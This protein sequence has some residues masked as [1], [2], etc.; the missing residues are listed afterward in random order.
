M[1]DTERDTT[2]LL[3]L[4][5][6][7]TTKRISPQDGR[8]FIVSA[9][10]GYGSIREDNGSTS[11]GADIAEAKLDGWTTNGPSSTSVTPDQANNEIVVAVP[12]DYEV[13]FS[14]D[15]TA[16]AG[17]FRFAAAV[18]G[19]STLVES[20]PGS[21]TGVLRAGFSDILTLALND[22]VSV[23]KSADSNGRSLTPLA[24]QL[25]LKRVG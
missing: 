6:D 22:A 4:H 15:Y 18:N 25:R 3:A 2:A 10:G 5:A 21:G 9:F 17:T 23:N 14:M 20:R 16:A 13:T 12:G 8:D 19:V 24:R 11:Q 1:A 7:N